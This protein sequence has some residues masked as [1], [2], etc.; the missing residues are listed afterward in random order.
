MKNELLWCGMAIKL[1]ELKLPATRKNG[2]GI[3]C[4]NTE[5]P[6]KSVEGERK[7]TDFRSSSSKPQ[8]AAVAPAVVITAKGDTRLRYSAVM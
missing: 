7:H 3:L 4:F 8:N 5:R 1:F 2:R 6:N